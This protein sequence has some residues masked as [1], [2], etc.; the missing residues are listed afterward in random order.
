MQILQHFLRLW[1][2]RWQKIFSVIFLLRLRKNKHNY[3]HSYDGILPLDKYYG[4]HEEKW[5]F[6]WNLRVMNLTK[7]IPEVLTNKKIKRCLTNVREVL[8]LIEQKGNEKNALK[9]LTIIMASFV[10]HLP[11]SPS[12]DQQ[13]SRKSITSWLRLYG[14][15]SW[16]I[17]LQSLL[18]SCNYGFKITAITW[19]H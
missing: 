6:W 2:C 10:K 7:Y 3:E 8:I 5:I 1:F 14:V 18:Q 13:W 19:Y 9:L 17:T 15:Q 4:I 16:I 11:P 12:T